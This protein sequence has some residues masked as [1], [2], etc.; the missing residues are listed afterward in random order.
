MNSH[1]NAGSLPPR[2]TR[3]KRRFP[4]Y[5]GISA[6]V[7]FL[8]AG[9][10]Y[11]QEKLPVFGG[12]EAAQPDRPE[13]QQPADLTA[14][15]DEENEKEKKKPDDQKKEESDKKDQAKQKEEPDVTVKKPEPEKEPAKKEP[16][17]NSGNG[18]SEATVSAAASEPD[19]PAPPTASDSLSAFEKEVVDLVNQERA[20]KGLSPLKADSELSDVARVKSKDMRDNHY[21]S[22]NSPT[23][24]SPFEMMKQFGIQYTAAGENIAAGQPTPEAVVKGWMDSDGHRANILNSQFT[25][26]GVGYAKG[27]SYGHYWTQQFIAK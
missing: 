18:P 11:A 21:F 1:R 23:Y 22:H 20:K 25:H 5:L 7:L 17:P 4:L 8:S 2:K 16:S 13:K 6:L 9:V 15:S 3:R 14:Q 10:L 24:G 19:K 26:I 12:E 27:G